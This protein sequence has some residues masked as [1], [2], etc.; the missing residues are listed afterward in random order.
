M[1]DKNDIGEEVIICEVW[2]DGTG[3]MIPDL[4]TA[5]IG[6]AMGVHNGVVEV[7]PEVGGGPTLFYP[8]AVTSET[9]NGSQVAYSILSR[10]HNRNFG[11]KPLNEADEKRLFRL[12]T[13]LRRLGT[14]VKKERSR[15][16]LLVV[17]SELEI[18]NRALGREALNWA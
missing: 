13:E 8:I 16:K 4:D 6:F 7:Q 3:N 12:G 17:L 2:A 5:I 18:I 11:S 9:K 14:T 15:K 10:I 1:I